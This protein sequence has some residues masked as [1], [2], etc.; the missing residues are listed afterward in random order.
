MIRTAMS[1]AIWCTPWICASRYILVVVKRL[2]HFLRW[3]PGGSDIRCSGSR[4][5]Q[6]GMLRLSP[7][8]PTRCNFGLVVPPTAEHLLPLFVFIEV[9]PCC[10]LCHSVFWI[11]LNSCPTNPTFGIVRI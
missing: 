9:L 3:A 10:I 8:L 7:G 2:D 1:L 4:A 11:I 6:W 5:Q